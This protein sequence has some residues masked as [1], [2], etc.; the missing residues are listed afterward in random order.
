[1]ASDGRN[2]HAGAGTENRD[3]KRL[4]GHLLAGLAF[5][6]RLG[7]L[8][9]VRLGWV[10]FGALLLLL[11]GLHKAEAQFGERVVQQALLLHLAITPRL[12]LK[13][14]HYVDPLTPDPNL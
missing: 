3:A 2:S 7:R 5:R 9:V 14:P 13:H 1:M 8:G 11:G 4:R 10:R 12:F 6:L